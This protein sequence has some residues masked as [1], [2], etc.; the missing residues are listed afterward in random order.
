MLVFL[1]LSVTEEFYSEEISSMTRS[2]K[3]AR[4]NSGGGNVTY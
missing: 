1:Y 3:V 4:L 2:Q